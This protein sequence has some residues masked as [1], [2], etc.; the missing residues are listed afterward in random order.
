MEIVIIGNG[1]A[2]VAAA[3]AIREFD[4]KSSITLV[5]KESSPLYSPCPLAEY[6]EQSVSR[7]D[8]FL[9]DD[10]FYFQNGITT[11][12]SHLAVSLDPDSRTVK[13]VHQGLAFDIHY[14]RL[15]IASGAKAVLPPVP[16]LANVPGVFTLKTL[17]DADAIIERLGKVRQAVVIGS[18]FIGLESAQ[19]LVRRG[20][21]VTLIEAQSQVLP[22]ML[23]REFAAR[24]EARLTAFGIS[25]LVNSPVKE[26]LGG[27]NGVTS[28][29]T[30]DREVECQL[31]VS[32]AGVRPDVA[33]LGSSGLQIGRGVEVGD[34][35]DTNLPDI[36]A[37]GDIIETSKWNGESDVIP[38]WPNAV[39]TGRIAGL[40][41][42][43]QERRFQGLLGVNVVRIF[44]QAISSFGIR[45]G[46]RILTEQNQD[47]IRRLVIDKGRIVGGQF[48]GDISGSGIYLELMRKQVDITA[49]EGI[50]LR[51]RFS[52]ARLLA[53]PPRP[54]VSAA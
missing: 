38:T 16:G 25:V 15:L 9:R 4:T 53:A 29:R 37:A 21:G 5:S 22:L 26:V 8:L 7:E 54:R 1:P 28:V 27:G 43:G 20:V 31:V 14:D 35:M 17:A 30:A 39:T 50:L 41:I 33:W 40:N 11:L 2:A 6:V 42:V 3:E 19:A 23:D 51:P 12:R 48:I 52:L 32:A 24:V 44:D 49:V 36:Y 46:E 45:E 34:R 18:G 47:Y 13:V 10:N